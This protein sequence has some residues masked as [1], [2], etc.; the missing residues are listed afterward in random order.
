MG[1]LNWYRV[2][3]H[4]GSI[5]MYAA[6]A[7]INIH[8]KLYSSQALILLSQNPDLIM[9]PGQFTIANYKMQDGSFTV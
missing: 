7:Y 2:F 9:S 4:T 8:E 5:H 6:C 3:L 1:T